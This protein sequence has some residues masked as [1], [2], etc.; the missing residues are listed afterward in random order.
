MHMKLLRRLLSLWTHK[1]RM[2]LI[3]D[4]NRQYNVVDVYDDDKNPFIY[5]QIEREP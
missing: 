2:I 1:E 4:G 3:T 5:V